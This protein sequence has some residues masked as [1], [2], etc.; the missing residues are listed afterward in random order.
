MVVP[1]EV[2]NTVNHTSVDA[3]STFIMSDVAFDESW[4]D[5][6]VSKCGFVL[7]TFRVNRTTSDIRGGERKN[8]CGPR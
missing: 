4:T 7:Q 3:P 6:D 5:D 8:V 1:E 2:K